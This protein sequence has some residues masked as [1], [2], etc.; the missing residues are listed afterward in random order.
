MVKIILKS[1]LTNIEKTNNIF[2]KNIL[3]LYNTYTI[4]KYCFM[5]NVFIYLT[6]RNAF[7]N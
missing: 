1:L 2:N 4:V 3:N 6:I 7:I 5:Y